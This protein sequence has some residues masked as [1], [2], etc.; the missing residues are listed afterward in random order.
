[1][2]KNVTSVKI[3]DDYCNLINDFKIKQII[4]DYLFNDI[5]TNQLQE[6]LVEETKMLRSIKNKKYK[7]IYLTNN[8]NYIL[9][10]KEINN[11]FYT[12]LIKKNFDFNYNEINYNKLEIFFIDINYPKE[13]Y[14][15]TIIEGRLEIINNES[16][17]NIYDI[18][19]FK[20]NNI[21]YNL[22]EKKD[23]I[24][25]IINNLDNKFF[26]FNIIEY[27]DIDKLENNSNNIGILFISYINDNKYIIFFNTKTVK[28][29]SYL[30][31]KKKT[32][33]VFDIYCL[34]NNNKKKIGIAHIPNLKTSKYFNK[35]NNEIIV[36]CWYSIKFNKW[37][38]FEILEEGKI[39]TFDEI[40]IK[41]KQT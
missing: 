16:I 13:Y 3:G 7:A 4:I 27:V 40:T 38:P 14:K 31:M 15:G 41:T 9:L 25:S 12:L 8:N 2:L 10:L 5:D 24:K 6:H 35:Y 36:K 11:I 28:E 33:D 23:L 30:Y 17:F 19:K 39:T 26:K 1:M 34:D 20:G 29:Y 22:D 21:N 18:L 37:V 32:T